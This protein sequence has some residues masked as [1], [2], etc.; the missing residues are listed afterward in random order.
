MAAWLLAM[1]LNWPL[2]LSFG[3]E[4]GYVGQ[5]KLF[6]EGRLR[7]LP[8]SPGIWVPTRDGPVA[9]YTLVLPLLITPLLAIM[10]RA[11][12]L[13]G[14]AAAL[15]L[16][17]IAS[18]ALRSWGRSPLW[19][20]L[21]LAHP[22]IVIIARTV[23]SDLLLAF[24][25]VASWW[26]L[27]GDRRIA[28]VLSFIGL[29][30][31]KP[32]GFLLAVALVVGEG[33]TLLPALRA[34]QPA[35]FARMRLGLLAFAAG[36]TAA[37]TS[38]LLATGHL[39]FG[40]NHEFLGTPP[41]WFRY[42]PT[43]GPAHLQSVLLN[44]PLLIAGAWAFWRKRDFG[45]LLLISGMGTMMCFYFFVD[46]GTSWLESLVLSPRLILPVV[47]FL[48]IGYAEVVATLW[49]RLR[50]G[51]R[52]ITPALLVV[53]ALIA[54]GIGAR[55]RRWQ[56]PMARALAAATTIT[57][58]AGVHELGL[59]ENACKAGL[60]YDGPT[61]LVN[62]AAQEAVILCSTRAASYRQPVGDYT[63]DLPGYKS[64]ASADGFQVLVRQ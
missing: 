26:A 40:Y 11:I 47:A 20:L 32:I 7:A 52:G 9:Q 38:N 39:W 63:C 16:T 1:L 5:A 59:T 4:I 21:V 30:A 24:F 48:M 53:P 50:L 29:I 62:A 10:P 60:L 2:S 41:F 51:I 55:H 57:G 36:L 61:R 37:F 35:A 54:F 58:R 12:F 42:L 44:P 13:S 17:W 27:R 14:A 8:T 19:A 6:L 31:T 34:R 25:A 3:D 43:T 64:E 28:T 49:E 15:G 22:T 46:F 45:P 23:M 33:V 18:R 56:E